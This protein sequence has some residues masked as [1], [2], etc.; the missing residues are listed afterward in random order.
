MI[1]DLNKLQLKAAV[2]EYWEW[3]SDLD[4]A[5]LASDARVADLAERLFRIF[6]LKDP[7]KKTAKVPVKIA[8]LKGF[9]L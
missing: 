6:R 4:D 3:Q 8:Q 9:R 2:D 5:S 7:S 1:R